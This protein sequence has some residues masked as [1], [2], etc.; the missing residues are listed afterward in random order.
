[1]TPPPHLW[2]FVLWITLAVGLAIPVMIAAAFRHSERPLTEVCVRVPR[3]GGAIAVWWSLILALSWFGAFALQREALRPALPIAIFLP[4]MLGAIWMLRSRAAS[5]ILNSLPLGWLIGVQV[6]RGIG[7]LFLLLHDQGL[8]PREFAGPAGCGDITIGVLAL[9]LALYCLEE[10][11][12][13]RWLAAVWNVLGIA[14]MLMAVSLGFLSSPS[15]IQQLAFDHPNLLISRFPLV[16]I[17]TFI[18]PISLLLHLAAL[19]KL[20]DGLR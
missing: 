15:P 20:R 9:P 7:A 18:V 5:D 17:P 19:K 10:R 12:G 3:V 11:P 2:L 6:Y 13:H 1:M 4:V 16:I 14:D 8:M